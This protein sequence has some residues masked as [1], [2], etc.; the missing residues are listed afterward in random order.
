MSDAPSLSLVTPESLT[1]KNVYLFMDGASEF[2]PPPGTKVNKTFRKNQVDK[3]FVC[4][5]SRGF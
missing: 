1:M 4:P 2:T 5:R 3:F